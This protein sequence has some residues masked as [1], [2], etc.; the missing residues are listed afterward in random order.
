MRSVAPAVAGDRLDVSWR[1]DARSRL[2][3]GTGL[4][5]GST[6]YLAMLHLH[7]RPAFAVL[8]G[9]LWA[10]LLLL[11]LAPSARVVTR[12]RWFLA[13]ASMV[14]LLAVLWRDSQILLGVDVLAL[15]G[16]VALG[17]PGRGSLLG[18]GPSDLI[19]RGVRAGLGVGTGS[20]GALG[21]LDLRGRAWVPQWS[22][23]LGVVVISP[24]LVLFVAL[25][26]NAD[27]LFGRLFT[28]LMPGAID[29]VVRRVVLVLALSWVAA[30]LLWTLTRPLRTG[31]LGHDWADRLQGRLPAGMVVSGI[32]AVCSIFALFLLLQARFLAGGRDF[33]M[34]TTDLTFA[35]YARRGFFELVV[36]TALTLPIL[37]GGEWMADQQA[38]RARK[39]TRAAIRVLLVLL[40]GI[41]VSAGMR[42]GVYAAEFGLTELRL[43]TSAFMAWLGFVLV[44]FAVTVMRGRRGRFVPGALGVALLVLL[45]LNLLNPAAW[46]VRVNVA[47]A[48][49]GHSLDAAHVAELGA[50]GVGT[51]L[52]SMGRLGVS[53]RC[54]LAGAL[55]RRWAVPG[56]P[57]SQWNV[58]ARRV[59]ARVPDIIA[60]WE[61]CGGDAS[62]DRDS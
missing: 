20:L 51:A 19:E 6:W 59:Q 9:S 41:V 39:A 24:V 28:A 27:P 30:G 12:D 61:A 35:E 3:L 10:A 46:I 55:H 40:A 56:A 1:E 62:A 4:A 48:V 18:T 58:E 45:A 17:V 23:G 5:V 14:L 57:G 33:V 25:L 60:A 22:V 49:A 13:S 54:A 7:D 37:L 52:A 36:V 53:D 34:R 31:E 29:V 42:M 50:G 2:V 8:F 44:W 47:R 38:P 11:Q 21:A 15:A 16:L 32:T 43:Y 26:G